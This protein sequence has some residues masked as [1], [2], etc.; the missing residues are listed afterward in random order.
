MPPM[1]YVQRGDVPHKRHTQFRK[2]DGGLYAEQL[3]GSP[4]T[5]PQAA[6]GSGVGFPAA[7]R[8]AFSS[9]MLALGP[10]ILGNLRL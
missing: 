7:L 6:A 3:S 2:P 5:A 9:T 10:L 8:R 1:F 4:F